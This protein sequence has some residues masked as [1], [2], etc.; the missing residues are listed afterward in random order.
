[1]SL[2]ALFVGLSG[3]FAPTPA[4]PTFAHAM[5]VGPA[6]TQSVQP[7]VPQD[8][9]I[10]TLNE[11]VSIAEQNAFGVRLAQSN[12]RKTQAQIDAAKG[13]LGPKATLGA[14]YTRYD[15]APFQGRIDS[16][17]L[18][19]A[20]TLNIDLAGSLARSV[21]AAKDVRRTADL[22]L[23]NERLALKNRVRTAYYGVVQA[24]WDVR[25]K[26]DALKSTSLRLDIGRK[27]FEAG[28][29]ANFDVLRLETD[30]TRAQAALVASRIAAATARQ[31]LNN[32]LA[33][34]ISTPVAVEMVEYTPPTLKDADAYVA[35]ARQ[36]RPDLESAAI[37]VSVRELI[38]HNESKG[39]SPSLS[40]TTQISRTID[41]SQFQRQTVG[42]GIAQITWPI[43]DS[44]I[45]KARVK[46]ADEDVRQAK[47][48]LEQATLG[49]E[50][51]VR[52]AYLR[53]QNA[54]AQVELGIQ[55]LA[56]AQEGL[57]LANLLFEAGKGILL[58]VTTAQDTL[59]RAE[60]N[61]NG[62]R[63]ALYTAIADLQRAIGTDDIELKGEPKL[64]TKP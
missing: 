19:A 3:L 56:E 6:M 16:K 46:Q 28:K 44:G 51:D 64:E 39:L 37:L 62:A 53:I 57:R 5:V 30:N 43:Y 34:P 58:D 15:Q 2:L 50:L 7:S 27:R 12:A 32:L 29:I 18:T 23:D 40:L 25:S 14:N 8:G 47:I 11:A 17:Q 1:M 33:R 21:K 60:S 10:L 48:T 55:Q 24:D 38:R 59:T 52:S 49:A 54:R 9:N 13:A 4:E 35:W 63:Y 41:A 26:E 45:T 61:L 22:A 20:I 36:A 42:V 31:L